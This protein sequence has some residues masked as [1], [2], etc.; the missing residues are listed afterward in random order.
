MRVHARSIRKLAALAGV[1][2]ALAG[3]A[4]RN[5]ERPVLDNA[6]VRPGSTPFGVSGG[7]AGATGGSGFTGQ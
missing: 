2:L 1:S 4:G 6:V 7:A 5:G 3:C